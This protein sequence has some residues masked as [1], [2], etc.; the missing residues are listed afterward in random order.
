VKKAEPLVRPVK[1]IEPSRKPENSR[2]AGKK[3][4]KENKITLKIPVPKA[5]IVKDN[6]I[7]T[8]NLSI[9]MSCCSNECRV[10]HHE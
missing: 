3:H 7:H 1:M 2:K 4:E 8:V 10:V 5:S 6:M 9:Y